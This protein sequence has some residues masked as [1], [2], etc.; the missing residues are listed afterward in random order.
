MMMCV[1]VHVSSTFFLLFS[2]SRSLSVC[3]CGVFCLSIT[4]AHCNVCMV[5]VYDNVCVCVCAILLTVL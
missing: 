2:F 4:F 5:S 3:L 1:Y